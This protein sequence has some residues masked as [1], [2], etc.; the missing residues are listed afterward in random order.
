[1]KITK[2]AVMHVAQLARLELK[3]DAIEKFSEQI[4]EI[5]EHVD[6][7][8]RVNTEGIIPTSHAISLINAFRD[9]EVSNSL[10]RDLTLANA[11]QAEAGSFVVPKV[12]G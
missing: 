10:D 9:D 4:G 5:L 7:L 12:V 2:E 11:P 6:S 8:K 1:M 3:K